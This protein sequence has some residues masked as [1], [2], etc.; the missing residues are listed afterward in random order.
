MMSWMC[1]QLWG[2]ADWGTV[3]GMHEKVKP[4]TYSQNLICINLKTVGANRRHRRVSF[5]VKW[6]ARLGLYFVARCRSHSGAM[7]NMRSGGNEDQYHRGLISVIS[8][9]SKIR[10]IILYFTS[11]L[12][13]FVLTSINIG[14]VIP[15]NEL[16]YIGFNSWRQ[17]YYSLSVRQ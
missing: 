11:Y 14:Y 1:I 15:G 7:I 6:I 10:N 5:H 4:S 12:C 17:Y 16:G 3:I 2:I 13:N 8:L 9:T